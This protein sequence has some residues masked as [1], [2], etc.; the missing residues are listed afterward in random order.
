MRESELHTP[1]LHTPTYTFPTFSKARSA[2]ITHP[3]P[4]NLACN[5][6]RK[7]VLHKRINACAPLNL[8]GLAHCGACPRFK[9]ASPFMRLW[10]ARD[11][12]GRL[13]L[14]V[15]GATNGPAAPQDLPRLKGARACNYGMA[16]NTKTPAITHERLR[17]ID[18]GRPFSRSI[19]GRIVLNPLV[20]ASFQEDTEK[21]GQQCCENIPKTPVISRKH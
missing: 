17:L 10:L 12:R 8:E 19:M 18:F 7:V 9:G 3:P 2:A 11:S 4:L 20:N 5:A 13:R 21:W 15:Y 14:C 1:H 16:E 6:L